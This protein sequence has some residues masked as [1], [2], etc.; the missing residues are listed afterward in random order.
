MTI[1]MYLIITWYIYGFSFLTQQVHL[2][3]EVDVFGR[4]LLGPALLL[5]VR[6]VPS[7]VVAFTKARSLST[8][9]YVVHS[10]RRVFSLIISPCFSRDF[11][12]LHISLFEF[13]PNLNTWNSTNL[14]FLLLRNFSNNSERMPPYI[15][16]YLQFFRNFGNYGKNALR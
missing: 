8:K 6:Q 11:S 10:Y 2:R 15:D 1:I 5:W 13:F 4:L 3:R 12:I 14:I 9:S 7:A 16:T